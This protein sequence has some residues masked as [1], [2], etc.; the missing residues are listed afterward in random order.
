M[1]A[2]QITVGNDS[3]TSKEEEKYVRFLR[4]KNLD[5]VNRESSDVQPRDTLYTRKIKRVIDVLIAFPAALITIPF[6]IVFAVCTYF[7]VGFPIIFMQTRCGYMNQP[8][9]MIK[10]RNMSNEKGPDGRLLPAKDRI[11]PFGRFMR[12]T[13]AD[14]LLNLLNVLKGDMSIIGPRPMPVF[15][16]ERMSERHK[17]RMAL[18]PGLECP[19]HVIDEDDSIC[20]WQK[21]FENSIWYV[22]NV[23]FMTDVKLFF[24]LFGMVFSYKKRNK[25]AGGLNYFVGYDDY[26]NATTMVRYKEYMAENGLKL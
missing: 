26:G 5:R 2:E 10:F 8:F 3:L 19:R 15:I 12:K 6:N 23:S 13:S 14:E 1:D 7:D 21:E 18:R 11:T 9:T 4:E 16:T 17:M 24:K 25:N 22:E 20:D